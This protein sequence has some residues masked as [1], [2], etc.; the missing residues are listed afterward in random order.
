MPHDTGDTWK[1][2]NLEERGALERVLNAVARQQ[3]ERDSRWHRLFNDESRR[4]AATYEENASRLDSQSRPAF[5]QHGDEL[6][7]RF[8]TSSEHAQQ[9]AH[10]EMAPAFDQPLPVRPPLEPA[11]SA[12]TERIAPA[13]VPFIPS[14]EMSRLI[15]AHV[16]GPDPVNATRVMRPVSGHETQDVDGK[17]MFGRNATSD[18]I[19]QLAPNYTAPGGQIARAVQEHVSRS[20]EGEVAEAPVNTLTVGQLHS[21]AVTGADTLEMLAGYSTSREEGPFRASRRPAQN[22][23]E[24]AGLNSSAFAREAALDEPAIGSLFSGFGP[25]MGRNEEQEHARTQPMSYAR[26]DGWQSDNRDSSN[27][28]PNTSAGQEALVAAANEVERLRAAVRQT[29]DD[30]ERVRGFVN[31]PMPAVPVNRGAFRI[32]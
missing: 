20:R 5:L 13:M 19:A 2:Q 32:S 11:S 15:A 12:T 16:E 23:I 3:G 18:P 29:I 30:L 4:H 8:A 26:D 6:T 1:R 28:A 31:P 21:L 25:V 14:L 7:D 24:A 22:Q 17:N 10:D 27:S 9:P